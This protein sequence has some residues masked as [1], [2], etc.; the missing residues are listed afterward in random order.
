MR[1]G[2]FLVKEIIQLR[3][4]VLDFSSASS[5]IL[6]HH[7]LPFSYFFSFFLNFRDACC[8]VVKYKWRGSSTG[9]SSTKLELQYEALSSVRKSELRVRFYSIWENFCRV[10]LRLFLMFFTESNGFIYR[11]MRVRELQYFCRPMIG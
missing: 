7:L 3:F 6:I 1:R 8:V 11:G 4:L 9:L 2:I 10:K 5:F